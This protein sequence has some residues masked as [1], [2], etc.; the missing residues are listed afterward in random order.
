MPARLQM[1]A[2][3]YRQFLPGEAAIRVDKPYCRSQRVGF[4]FENG[5]SVRVVA[6]M[7][8]TDPAMRR[9]QMLVNWA[10]TACRAPGHPALSG[11]HLGTAFRTVIL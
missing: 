1:Y 5:I 9:G 2:Q 7:P 3:R 8:D 11:N 6:E 10:G 4:D